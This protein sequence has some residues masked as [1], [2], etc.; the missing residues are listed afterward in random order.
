MNPVRKWFYGKKWLFPLFR[1]MYTVG[2]GG[3]NYGNVDLRL[4]GETWLLSTLAQRKDLLILDVGANLGQYAQAIRDVLGPSVKVH[5]FEPSP[6]AQQVFTNSHPNDPALHLHPYGLGAQSVQNMVLHA[7][8][9]GG[10][11]SSIFKKELPG[12]D[13]QY[14]LQETINIRTL[15]EFLSEQGI[16]KVDLLKID[17]EGYELEV[18]KGAKAALANGAIDR[19]QFE[20]GEGSVAARIFMK[21]FVDL[22]SPGYQL[23]YLLRNGLVPIGRYSLTLENFNTTNYVALRKGLKA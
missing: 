10:S 20:F 21:D 23:F 5:S 8:K 6:A 1:K 22:L 15:D 4:N 17:V 12:S 3:M 7:H 19:I 16:T 13:Y 2:I 9:M 14:G 11:G 18:L